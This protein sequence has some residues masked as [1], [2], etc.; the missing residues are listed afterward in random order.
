MQQN[1]TKVNPKKKQSKRVKGLD[2]PNE[3]QL[4]DILLEPYQEI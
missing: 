2:E 4:S 3:Q 1:L